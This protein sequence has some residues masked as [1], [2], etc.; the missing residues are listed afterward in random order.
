MQILL[1][2]SVCSQKLAP[3][4]LHINESQSLLVWG[5]KIEK[6]SRGGGIESIRRTQEKRAERIELDSIFPFPMFFF[7]LTFFWGVG[8]SIFSDRNSVTFL[9]HEARLF[10][11]IPMMLSR[12]D[13]LPYCIFHV[14]IS[15]PQQKVK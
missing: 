15:L 12:I 7:F 3:H 6:K 1:Q 5:I 8:G 13:P 9:S 4:S 14:F 10:S 11:F 2:Q